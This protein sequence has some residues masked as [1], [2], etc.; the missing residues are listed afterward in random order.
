MYRIARHEALTPSTFLWEVEAPDVAADI[1]KV[2][3]RN[4]INRSAQAHILDHPMFA[5]HEDVP[6]SGS[7]TKGEAPP[8]H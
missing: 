8:E 2:E 7:A 1:N 4:W 3:G 5:P 6:T